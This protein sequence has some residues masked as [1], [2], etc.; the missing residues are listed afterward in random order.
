MRAPCPRWL[1][2]RVARLLPFV[3]LPL[4]VVAAAQAEAAVA[5]QAA[6]TAEVLP[7]ATLNDNRG[8]AGPRRGR[9]VAVTLELGAARWRP[10]GDSLI[11]F[12]MSA[13]NEAGRAPQVPGPLLRARVGDELHVTVRNATGREL[14]VSG[15]ADRG[16]GWRADDTLRVAAGGAREVRIR[17]TMP[18]AF[19]Y[20][21]ITRHP[22]DVH[23]P[24]PVPE[25]NRR[26]DAPLVGAFVVDPAGTPPG[27]P[28][29]ERILLI[30][31]G[32]DFGV[33]ERVAAQRA[34]VSYTRLVVNG[35][36]W[37]N[38]ERLEYTVGDT[39]RWRLI[40][41]AFLPHPMHLHGFYF[42][43]DGRGDFGRDTT[44]ARAARRMAVTE[45]LESYTT[46]RVTWVPERPGNWLFHC[47][48]LPHMS[49]MPGSVADGA[50]G[51]HGAHGVHGAH[52]AAAEPHDPR[53]HMAGM[54]VGIHV[55]ERAGAARPALHT[56]SAP[57]TTLT[58]YAQS[59]DSAREGGARGYGFVVGD[60]IAP[61][62]DS[63]R[64]PGAPIL[65]RRGEPVAITVHNRLA[66]R[67]SVHWHGMELESRYD[68]VGGWSGTPGS[69]TPAIA[70]GDSFVVH[71]TPAR[72]GTFIY[73]THDEADNELN[74]GLYGPLLVLEPGA[75]HDPVRDHVVVLASGAN[76]RESALRRRSTRHT[77]VVNGDTLPRPVT[78]A[79]GRNR[80]RL[81]QIADAD[82][83]ELRLVDSAGTVLPWRV[84]AKD[85]WTRPAAQ[86]RPR[87]GVLTIGVGETYDVELDAT[88]LA[89]AT[90]PVWLEV[91]TRYYPGWRRTFMHTARV[92]IVATGRALT[93]P[94]PTPTGRSAHR[95]R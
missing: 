5:A 53:D 51:A 78:L 72:A 40:N 48:L 9:V 62:R 2:G 59:R 31:T 87:P 37:P 18:G 22:D 14:L 52:G 54:V 42:R 39:V 38:T 80:L 83:K 88:A 50:H 84:L 47:H 29:R 10:A 8:P 86:Q 66:K 70:A 6:G 77:P 26:Q 95:S 64:R 15:L 25:K 23:R 45:L 69:V 73:H 44:Y 35:A 1:S 90:G 89:A 56:A 71:F 21:A 57:R 36:S 68:G 94:S 7:L 19:W 17:L 85:G 76:G 82:V 74:A 13:F 61:A 60:S 93:S 24:S 28:P 67:L 92:P 16:A 30:H 55:R 34:R 75:R 46:A 81:I 3:L 79:P 33:L 65:V 4:P 27:G 41:S 58:L 12:E 32:V 63:I 20:D 43:V 11:E 49:P 91:V